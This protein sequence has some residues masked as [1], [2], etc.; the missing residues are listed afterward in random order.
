MGSILVLVNIV[1]AVWTQILNVINFMISHCCFNFFAGD[2]RQDLEYERHYASHSY[3]VPEV[4]KNFLLHFQ[5][6]IKE[7]NLLEIQ[8]N[9]ENG[10]VIS[11]VLE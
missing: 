9:Y 5:Q 7:Q 1:N 3:I 10:Q 4:I 6:V 2:P 11:C 8:N